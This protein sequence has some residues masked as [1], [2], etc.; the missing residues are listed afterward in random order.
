[1]FCEVRAAFS[2]S[3][4]ARPFPSPP[5]RATLLSNRPLVKVGLGQGHQDKEME[6]FAMLAIG[7]IVW[8]VEDIPR[9]V[10][11][12]SAALHYTL[13]YPASE[14]WA[15]LIPEF[16]AG[17]QLSLSKVSSPKGPAPSHRPV[18]RRSGGRGRAAPCPRRH[19]KGLA[20]S[21]RRGLRGAAGSRG[22][23]LL[24][25]AALGLSPKKP[26]SEAFV[27][28]PALFIRLETVSPFDRNRFPCP[29]PA[30]AQLLAI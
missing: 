5:I 7:S 16:G 15:I 23:S 29:P 14:D 17:I 30:C 2:T 11:F 18:Y 10:A 21:S 9:A 12:W 4:T 20:L 27:K 13:K 6:V 1:M 26:K 28:R 8:G 19:Q 25:G 3:A 24:R 22:Q